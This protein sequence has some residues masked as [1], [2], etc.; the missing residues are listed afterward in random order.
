MAEKNVQ[1]ELDA[2]ALETAQL[3]LEEARD[4]NA[5]IRA[6]KEDKSRRNKQRQQQLRNDLATRRILSSRCSH[7]QGGSPNNPLGGKGATALNVVKMPDGFTK[8]VMCG[9]CR[10]RTFS[11]HPRNQSE[12]A[13]QGETQAEAKARAVKYRED[14]AAFD[15][16]LAMSKDTLTEEASQEMDC[17][18]TITITNEDGI[19]VLP[20]RP[21]DSYA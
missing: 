11:P 17:G 3:N 18:V 9:V 5:R 20:T 10:L 6:E 16:L 12:K 4:R 19:P 15:K 7:R 13:R 2:I 14:L 1:A 8:L 21:C